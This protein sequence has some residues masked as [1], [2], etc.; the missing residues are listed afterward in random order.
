[1]SENNNGHE[2]KNG[3]DSKGRFTRGN[4]VAVGNRGGRKRLETAFFESFAKDFD[5]HG[6]AVIVEVRMK[7]P[8]DYLRIAASILPK[9]DTL[10]VQHRMELLTDEE[11][12]RIIREAESGE[13]TLPTPPNPT[14]LN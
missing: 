7:N 10:I 14:Q 9:N 6:A 5:E 13:D 12:V 4:T 11:L 3:H 2:P 8:L 1:M